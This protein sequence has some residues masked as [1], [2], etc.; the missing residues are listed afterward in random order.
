LEAQAAS[1]LSKAQKRT[2]STYQS[3]VKSPKKAKVIKSGDTVESGIWKHE[4]GLK[5]CF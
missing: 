4:Y 1:S 5:C 2:L 3:S